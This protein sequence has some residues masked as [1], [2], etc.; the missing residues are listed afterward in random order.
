MIV[1]LFQYKMPWEFCS[2]YSA[3][4]LNIIHSI[5]ANN[6]NHNSNHNC[7][8]AT[9]ICTFLLKI[10]SIVQITF[11]CSCLLGLYSLA[12]FTHFLLITNFSH[13]QPVSVTSDHPVSV[14][15]VVVVGMNC[16]SFFTS[17]L[18]PLHRFA[19]NFVW[20]FL[21]WT[22]TKFVKMGVLS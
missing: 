6:S 22:P 9:N 19:S 5:T 10:V 2:S 16:F 8:L 17:S 15:V 21:G 1:Y 14:V 4:H 11:I 18:E 20:M 13:A 3:L 7:S 12:C